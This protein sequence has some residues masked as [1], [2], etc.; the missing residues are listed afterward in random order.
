MLLL[1]IGRL[2]FVILFR[3]IDRFQGLYKTYIVGAY[4]L[5]Q[6]HDISNLRCMCT[7]PKEE[8]EEEEE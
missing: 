1:W 4:L 3:V 6:N 8:E 7:L 5:I 2:Y